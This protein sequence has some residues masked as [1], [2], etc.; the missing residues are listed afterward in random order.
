MPALE[1]PGKGWFDTALEFGGKALEKVAPLVLGAVTGLGDYDVNSNSILA[2]C[3]NGE[4]GN[5]VPMVRNTKAG[6][7]IAHRE[8]IGDVLSTTDPF[9][10][11]SFPINP[12]M[13][14][15]FPWA[16]FLANNYENYQM[17]GCLFE[18]VSTASEYS[19]TAG[20]GY[21]A[22][23]TQYNALQPEF[24]DKKSM[25]NHEFA[26]S[27]KTSQNML[28]PIE[29]ERKQL[30]LGELYTRAGSLPANA[31]LKMYDLGK[32]TLA[33]GGQTADDEVIGEL[34]VTYEMELLV[35]RTASAS[36]VNID[37][38]SSEGFAVVAGGSYTL[39]STSSPGTIDP[40]S[41]MA[42]ELNG[43]NMIFPHGTRGKFLVS[44]YFRGAGSYA[45]I[46][47]VL[48]LQNCT[49]ATTPT[50]TDS[51]NL[52]ATV[53]SQ[54]EYFAIDVVQDGALISFSATV[55]TGF[56]TGTGRIIITQ[57]PR[58]QTLDYVVKPG[59]MLRK[60]FPDTQPTLFSDYS[61]SEDE[62]PIQRTRKGNSTYGGPKDEDLLFHTNPSLMN[63]L[64]SKEPEMFEKLVAQE[65][66]LK[67]Q[68][69][70]SRK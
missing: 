56:G 14:E 1:E 15:T 59:T 58:T 20:L 50:K 54:L 68:L 26:T 16:A 17:R 38:F 63:Y 8:Y 19:A 42:M 32:F 45:S 40:A 6:T 57:I 4:L 28:H 29:C 5:E 3:T 13:S 22:M 46:D 51:S 66:E 31:D 41:N 24:S 53:T 10:A 39:P 55:P 52:G 61:D 27:C 47:P 43:I 34:Y 35:P 44:V 70:R 9:Q 11:Q 25:L 49:L 2:A 60:F 7:I 23:A 33:V 21:V 18:F 64:R 36:G 67:L 69:E 30:A 62:E 37:Y 48:V 65:K 12:G